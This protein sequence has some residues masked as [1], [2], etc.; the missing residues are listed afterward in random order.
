MY[1]RA[2]AFQISEYA[3]EFLI[4]VGY[5]LST[6]VRVTI[7]IFHVSRGVLPHAQHI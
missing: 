4:I 3:A 2:P 5:I 7:E 1:P 6:A